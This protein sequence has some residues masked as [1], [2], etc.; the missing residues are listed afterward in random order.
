MDEKKLAYY[1]NLKYEVVIEPSEDGY[2]AHIPD[3]PGCITQVDD[4]AEIV[5]MMIDA[6]RCWLEVA[7]EKGIDIPLPKRTEDYSGKFN[8]RL[9]KSLH[10]K[11]SERAK[12]EKVSINQLA[13]YYIADGLTR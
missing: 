6:K 4:A 5:P 12:R 11:L 3:L 10:K 9:P 13:T 2:V 8:L 1:M 7:L